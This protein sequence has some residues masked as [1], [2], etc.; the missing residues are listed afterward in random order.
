[1]GILKTTRNS[2][3]SIRLLRTVCAILS[4]CLHVPSQSSRMEDSPSWV[5]SLLLRKSRIHSSL[6]QSCPLQQRRGWATRLSRPSPGD[7]WPDT[8]YRQPFSS[9][10]KT[11][12]TTC[13]FT[14]IPKQQQ[15]QIAGSRGSKNFKSLF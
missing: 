11:T 3:K 2:H 10:K 6:G 15:Q 9:P 8:N 5:V 12:T 7:V 4:I 1:M 13:G 14:E